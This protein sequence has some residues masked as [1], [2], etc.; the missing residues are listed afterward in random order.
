LTSG[1]TPTIVV[2]RYKEYNMRYT[3]GRTPLPTIAIPR[4]SHL[5]I[6]PGIRESSRSKKIISREL[7]TA[8]ATWGH[9]EAGGCMSPGYFAPG[10]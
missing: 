3:N 5:F 9:V 8:A 4:D 2:Y 6:P 1:Q 10:L 7:L